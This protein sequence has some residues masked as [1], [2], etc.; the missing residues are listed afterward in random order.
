M[1]LQYSASI[2][3]QR[4]HCEQGGNGDACMIIAL[5]SSSWTCYIPRCTQA[6]SLALL[7]IAWQPSSLVYEV[8]KLLDV[9][10]TARSHLQC[11]L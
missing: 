5:A 9:Q 11:V 6:L 8:C 7:A 4:A 1:Q 2:V 3:M 10:N